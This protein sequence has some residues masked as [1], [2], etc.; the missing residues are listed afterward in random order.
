MM[1]NFLLTNGTTLYKI[2]KDMVTPN[3]SSFS[4]GSGGEA[5]RGEDLPS[6]R[7]QSLTTEAGPLRNLSEE[8]LSKEVINKVSVEDLIRKKIQQTL[9]L[10]EA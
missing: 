6:F 4:A 2:K 7:A 10:G 9:V 8:E 3:S 1:H 5:S